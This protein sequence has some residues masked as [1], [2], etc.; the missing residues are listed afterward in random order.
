[1][2]PS[3]HVLHHVLGVLPHD[4]VLLEERLEEGGGAPLLPDLPDLLQP[5][6]T[7]PGP[8]VLDS[9]SIQISQVLD[10]VINNLLGKKSG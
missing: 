1:M 9:C 8:H 6:L 5:P 2:N 3:G 10:G 4:L 7:K